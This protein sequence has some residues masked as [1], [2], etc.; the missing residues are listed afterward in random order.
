MPAH[1]L[2]SQQR[3][4]DTFRVFETAFRSQND[5]QQHS[6]GYRTKSHET[7]KPFFQHTH[8]AGRIR[9]SGLVTRLRRRRRGRADTDTNTDRDAD[10]KPDRDAKPD[11]HAGR[12][13]DADA[14]DE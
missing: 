9:A 11:A 13:A 7:F 10:A 12:D 3:L 1:A 4:P 2:F 6:R 8:G 14:G 5:E